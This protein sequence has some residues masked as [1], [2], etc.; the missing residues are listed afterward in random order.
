[1]LRIFE[2]I[3]YLNSYPF[4]V[5]L[6]STV[7]PSVVPLL[8]CELPFGERVVSEETISLRRRC[9]SGSAIFLSRDVLC[10]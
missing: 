8:E 1:M 4:T 2:D 3:N 5:Y 6:F 7:G 10:S 9:S